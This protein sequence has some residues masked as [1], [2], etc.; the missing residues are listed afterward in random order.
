MVGGSPYERS[1]AD[2]EDVPHPRGQVEATTSEA[3]AMSGCSRYARL[4]HAAVLQVRIHF[5]PA[6]S[7]SLTGSSAPRLKTPA[8]RAGVRAMGGRAVGRDWDRLAT[9]RLLATMSL[10]GEI[11]VPQPERCD[12]RRPQLLPPGKAVVGSAGQAKP[13][14]I[15]C[16]CQASGRRECASSLAAVRSRGW[17]PSRMAWVMSGAR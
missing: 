9:W 6:D 12:P 8:F 14:T 2:V 1:Q 11:P 10:L 17:C 16:S 13:S 7:P 15:R 3:L 4:S 5:P